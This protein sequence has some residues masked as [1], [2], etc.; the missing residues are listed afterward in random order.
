MRDALR[1]VHSEM[2]SRGVTATTDVADDLP[3]VRGD[4]VQIL[5]VLLNL[6]KNACDAMTE[7]HPQ[8]RWIVLRAI[9]DG[10]RIEVSVADR[11]CGIAEEKIDHIFE[12]FVTTKAEGMG[13][14]LAVCRTIIKA[15]DGRLW[16]SSNA[17]GGAT[18][19]FTL[20][21]ETRDAS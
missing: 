13:L 2:I 3:Q 7:T 10:D 14:G 15:H 18:F 16:A 4:R 9:A 21:T 11:G 19:R 12:P 20:P 8:E 5:Q 6:I 17:A 1:L